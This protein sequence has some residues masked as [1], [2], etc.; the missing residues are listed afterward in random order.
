MQGTESDHR[1]KYQ[2]HALAACS[3]IVESVFIFC[4]GNTKLDGP[5]HNQSQHQENLVPADA[6]I[7]ARGEIC[8]QSNIQA[9]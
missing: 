1:S 8:S 5:E 6:N 3:G 7:D 2:H 9:Q 4:Q